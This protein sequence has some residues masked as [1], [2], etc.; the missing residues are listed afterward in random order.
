MSRSPIQQ[1]AIPGR[2]GSLRLV[3]P[4]RPV[5][6][7][8]PPRELLRAAAQQLDQ[9][10]PVPG[11]DAARAIRLWEGLLRGQW[12]LVDWF[13]S[14]GRRFIIARV[15]PPSHGQRRGLTTRERQVTLS[16]ALGE[17]NKVTG[18]QL[19]LSPSRVS[20]LLKTAMHKLGVR[21]KAQLV[22][23]VRILNG[24]QPSAAAPAPIAAT[25]SV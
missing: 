13:D 10:R 21:T 1:A 12:T 7:P 4:A 19:G 8:L 2:S 23:M 15:N 3:H 25:N 11:E 14:D 16:A 24:R 5:P 22:V 20:A 17:S 9:S 6:P 18:Y